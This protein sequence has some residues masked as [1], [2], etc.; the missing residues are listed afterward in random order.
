MH[1]FAV[2]TLLEA[3]GLGANLQHYNPMLETRAS[4]EWNIPGDWSLKAQLVFGKPNGPA[5]EKTVE[6]LE[7]R[8]FVYGN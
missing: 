1:Q 4:E 2:W 7:K 8:L 3:E 5:R 6:P